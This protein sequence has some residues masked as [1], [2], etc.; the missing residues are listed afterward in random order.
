M[1][2]CLFYCYLMY[3]GHSLQI[4]IAVNNGKLLIFVE[5]VDGWMDG[6]EDGWINK[7][8]SVILDIFPHTN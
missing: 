2:V 5:W 4:A 7:H 1:W 6:W 3:N 8:F